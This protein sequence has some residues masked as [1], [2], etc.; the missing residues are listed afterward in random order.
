MRLDYQFGFKVSETWFFQFLQR[1]L[2]WLIPAQL[3]IL[4]LSTSVVFVET[5]EEAL[6]ERFG[7]PV[8]GRVV[9]GAG[10]HLKWPWPIDR[11]YRHSTGQIQSFNIGF[12]HD[13]KQEAAQ[14][15]VLW[16][17]SHYKDEFNLLVASRETLTNTN[18][19]KRSPPVNLL[20]VSIPV[21]FQITNIIDWAYN[22]SDPAAL[23]E[24]IG[25]REVVRYLVSVDLHEMMSGARFDAGEV[26]RQRIQ[27]AAS[28][29]KLGAKIIFVGLQDVHPPVK[30]ASAYEA[31][32]GARQKKEAD[33]LNAKAFGVETNALAQSTSTTKVNEALAN[34][35]RT[36]AGALARAALFTNQLPAYTAAPLTYA[37]RAY[38]Q[39]LVRGGSTA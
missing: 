11:V 5:G 2:L 25:T 32:V 24:K 13:E 39:A 8:D 37:T 38:L 26:L 14:K 17:V 4:L 31:V 22:N 3:A 21:Q 1:A 16:T 33:I 27:E 9:L 6:L 10:L 23:L 12:V 34:R 7:R 15:S 18:T 20:S 30:V 19:G 28:A 35:K 36:E 29:L